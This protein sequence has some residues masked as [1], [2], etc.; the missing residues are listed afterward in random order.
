MRRRDGRVCVDCWTIWRGPR[1]F[2]CVWEPLWFGV[3]V[4]MK[5]LEDGAERMGICRTERDLREVR[6][7]WR[8]IPGGS[9]E[10]LREGGMKEE[11]GNDLG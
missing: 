1:A 8:D 7:D 3:G 10:I 6:T 11:I 2:V 5:S 9:H 4:S